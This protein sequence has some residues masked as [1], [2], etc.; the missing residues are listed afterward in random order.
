MVGVRDCDDWTQKRLA[1]Y[2]SPVRTFTTD[3]LT[4]NHRNA[5]TAGPGP[6]GGILADR[7]GAEH[8]HIVSM[9]GCSHRG[10]FVD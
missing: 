5:E 7:S 9:F 4:L 10:P 1:R 8:D 2:T 3:Q 6:L